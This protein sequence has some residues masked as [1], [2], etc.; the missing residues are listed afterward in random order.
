MEIFINSSYFY[1]LIKF[2]VKIYIHKK[3]EVKFQNN[4]YHYLKNCIVLM[5][6]KLILNKEIKC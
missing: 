4:K 6:L 3:K 2:I 5:T 1:K